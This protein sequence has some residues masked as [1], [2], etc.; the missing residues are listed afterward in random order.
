MEISK[1]YSAIDMHSGGVPV[2]IVTGGLP[3]VPEASQN[4]RAEYFAAHFDQV[5]QLLMAE[6]RGHHG[7]TGVIVTT[8]VRK[9][10][11]FGLLFMNNEGFAPISASGIVAMVT[12]WLESGQINQEEAVRGIR[13]DCESGL[14]TAYADCEGNELKSVTVEGVPSFVIAKNLTVMVN[15]IAFTVDVAYSGAFYVVVDAKTFGGITTSLSEMQY[16]GSSIR[17]A[18]ETV[19]HA[20]HPNKVFIHGI[21]GVFMYESVIED[22]LERHFRA[23]TILADDQC[24]RSPGGTGTCAHVMVMFERG[25][26]MPN[27]KVI[28][29]GIAGAKATC[30]LITS[31]SDQQIS[32]TPRYKADAYLLGWMNFVLDPSDPFSKGFLLR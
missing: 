16:W 19:V 32:I 5:R 24:D 17:L 13:I 31:G 25:E 15:G 29:S 14:I 8:P 2:R 23:V 20:V 22:S 7:M 27:E 12:A 11:H 26:L 9:D 28:Y 6:P 1:W 18:V 3:Q 10:S 30:T 4:E 21:H